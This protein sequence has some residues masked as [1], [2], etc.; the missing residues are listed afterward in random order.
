MANKKFEI[1]IINNKAR[2]AEAKFN[3]AI[4]KV[5]NIKNY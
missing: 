4:P 3:Q 2:E 1:L 5:K